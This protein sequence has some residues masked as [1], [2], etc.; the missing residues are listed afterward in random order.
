MEDLPW[1]VGEASQIL[2]QRTVC[3]LVSDSVSWLATT[4]TNATTH[5]TH[6]D[7]AYRK[8]GKEDRCGHC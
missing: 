7:G 1:E 2:F 8:S 6:F 4:K 3:E 5:S